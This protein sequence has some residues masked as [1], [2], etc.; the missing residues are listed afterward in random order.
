[1]AAD[2]CDANL[3]KGQPTTVSFFE[4]NSGPFMISCARASHQLTPQRH[5][6]VSTS[7][8]ICASSRWRAATPVKVSRVLSVR[9][10]R[11]FALLCPPR[12]SYSR[13]GVRFLCKLRV[14]TCHHRVLLFPLPTGMKVHCSWVS[15]SGKACSEDMFMHV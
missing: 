8:Y 3:L 14:A 10:N 7:G 6:D 12:S 1:M 2:G 5:N 11:I 4:R 15:A 13:R 9:L